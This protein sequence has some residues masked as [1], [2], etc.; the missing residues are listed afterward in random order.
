[1]PAVVRVRLAV[2]AIALLRAQRHR[3]DVGD[4]TRRERRHADRLPPV[5]LANLDLEDAATRDRDA[6]LRALH[7]A[8][9]DSDH[10]RD[11]DHQA[12][13]WLLEHGALEDAVV[14]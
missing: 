3:G 2:A 4:H 9:P 11:R 7:R 10:A 14:G 5:E 1:M 13:V 8:G 6:L 12:A